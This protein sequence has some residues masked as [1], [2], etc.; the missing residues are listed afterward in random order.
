MDSAFVIRVGTNLVR[1]AETIAARAG[2]TLIGIGVAQEDN[3]TAAQRLYP[4]LG[5]VPDGRGTKSTRWGE[6]LYLTKAI[7][8]LA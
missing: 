5:Y 1:A 7:S 4:K 2:K 6:I 8:S 3:Y